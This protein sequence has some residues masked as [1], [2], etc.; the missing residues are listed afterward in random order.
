M[1]G[2]P[3]EVCSLEP[4]T[5]LLPGRFHQHRPRRHRVPHGVCGGDRRVPRAPSPWGTTV[6]AHPQFRIPGSSQVIDG[7]SVQV[8]GSRRYHDGVAA[9]VVLKATNEGSAFR[10]SPQ[11][12]TEHAADV[13]DDHHQAFSEGD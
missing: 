9:P 10:R 12:L 11:A 6:D 5:R 8:G 13:P 3:L 7:E 2:E 1:F 4:L